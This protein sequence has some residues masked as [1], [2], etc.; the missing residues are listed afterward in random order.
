[1]VF[2]SCFRVGFDFV[3][4]FEGCGVFVV[5]SKGFACVEEH[6]DRGRYRCLLQIQTW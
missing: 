3:E 2:V 1:M 4:F 5:F 6:R